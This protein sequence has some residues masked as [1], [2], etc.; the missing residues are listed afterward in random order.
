MDIVNEGSLLNYKGKTLTVVY[1]F[2]FYL[3]SAPR[4]FTR[5]SP[6]LRFTLHPILILRSWSYTR[7][8]EL[9]R[10]TLYVGFGGRPDN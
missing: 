4:T 3:E 9:L 8:T 6:L 7:K 1:N 2:T 5:T 10:L